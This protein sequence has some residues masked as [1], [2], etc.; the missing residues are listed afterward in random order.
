[1]LRLDFMQRQKAWEAELERSAPTFLPDLIE[2][3]NEG[4][5]FPEE[6]EDLP[7]F[8]SQ[9][10]M[11]SQ[12]PAQHQQ[13][14]QVDEFLRDESEEI[15]ALV[16]YMSREK[17]DPE[18]LRVERTSFASDGLWSDDTDYDAIFSEVLS[19]EENPVVWSQRSN[20]P[21]MGGEEMDMS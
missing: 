7:A 9:M 12:W 14:E 21:Q 8:N 18:E 4:G 10:Q 2:Q 15:E 16:A 20:P 17:E 1:M 5:F 13:E 19:Q 3:E 6:S 11:S